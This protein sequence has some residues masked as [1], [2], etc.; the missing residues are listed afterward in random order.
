L[1]KSLSTNQGNENRI[2]NKRQKNTNQHG[3]CDVVAPPSVKVVQERN[4]FA[5][6]LI[7]ITFE[8]RAPQPKTESKHYKSTFEE[9][10]LE[11][12]IQ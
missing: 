12:D 10:E 3:S 6:Q 8:I 9:M 4:G 11:I 1:V 5:E 2:N 7:G